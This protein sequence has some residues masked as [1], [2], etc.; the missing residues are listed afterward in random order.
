[1]AEESDSLINVVGV[2]VLFS[3]VSVVIFFVSMLVLGGLNNYA[4]QDV[5][6]LLVD[7]ISDGVVHSDFQV[8][9]DGLSGLG[10]FLPYLDYLWFGSF[11]TLV[12]SSLVY[13]YR[14]DRG[15]FFGIMN[16][17]VFGV[18]IFTYVGGLFIQI[19][20]WFKTEI[21]YNV[22]PTL[23][24]QTPFF[25]WYLD[26]VGVINLVLIVLCVVANFVDLDL[27]RFNKRKGD[28]VGEI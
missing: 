10:D 28:D 27:A 14:V 23:S 1:M 17:A 19:T 21:L 12:I 15:N 7:L 20:D 5:Y 3:F 16:L 22:F 4:L 24:G 8:S 13:S 11:I 6:G 2:V 26:N 18:I 9:A 25:V